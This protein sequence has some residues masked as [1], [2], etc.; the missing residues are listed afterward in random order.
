LT[1]FNREGR[2]VG[3]HTTRTTATTIVGATTTAARHHEV[4]GKKSQPD[5]QPIARD[6]AA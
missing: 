4:V 1:F 5:G 6:I 2:A 3:Q